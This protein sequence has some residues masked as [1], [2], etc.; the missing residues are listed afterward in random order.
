MTPF[1]CG[2]T[3]RLRSTHGRRTNRGSTTHHSRRGS[4]ICASSTG[5]WMAGSSCGWTSFAGQGGA[6]D[7]Q[8]STSL[9]HHLVP[10]RERLGLGVL[11]VSLK[12]DDRMPVARQRRPPPQSPKPFLIEGGRPALRFCKVPTRQDVRS[13]V[14]L[15]AHGGVAE[16]CQL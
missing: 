15:H 11:D 4:T 7:P 14:V 10:D 5:R 9:L 2:S 1:A 8:G 12:H 3:A 13:D 6:L 16:I